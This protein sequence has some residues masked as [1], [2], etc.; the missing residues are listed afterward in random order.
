MNFVQFTKYCMSIFVCW[1]LMYV[2]ISSNNKVW[3]IP[4]KFVSFQPSL[5]LY[6]YR[7]S[8]PHF[9]RARLCLHICSQVKPCSPIP[10]LDF[11]CCINAHPKIYLWIGRISE[12]QNLLIS[13]LDR[14]HSYC[15]SMQDLLL[16]FQTHLLVSTEPSTNLFSIL[17]CWFDILTSSG[18]SNSWNFV[19]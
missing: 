3:R 6:Y 4:W 13:L 17:F 19:G 10:N 7:F 2:F 14:S 8:L 15:S 16:C 18:S 11:V 12:F 1:T 5:K 9:G